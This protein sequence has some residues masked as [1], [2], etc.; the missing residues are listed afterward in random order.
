MINL[1]ST[2]VPEHN[3][4]AMRTFRVKGNI[5][6]S[7]LFCP[8]T[9]LLAYIRVLIVEYGIRTETREERVIVWGGGSDDRRIGELGERDGDEAYGGGAGPNED[10]CWHDRLIIELWV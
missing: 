1:A 5:H 10:L 8:R 2:F 7:L 9:N 3:I 6:T 4:K